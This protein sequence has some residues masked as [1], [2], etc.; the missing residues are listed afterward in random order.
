[1]REEGAALASSNLALRVLEGSSA[2]RELDLVSE[3]FHRIGRI[4]PEDQKVLTIPPEMPVRTALALM[5]K[6]RYSQ[7]PVVSGNTVTGVFSYRSFA[8][9]AA[10]ASLESWTHQKCAP[11]DLRV[12]DCTEDFSFARFKEEMVN[13]F[14]PLDR[15]NGILVGS[16]EKLI[17]ILTPM[18]LLRYLY[19][20]AGPFVLVSEIELV[21]R[22]LIRRVLDPPA[23]VAAAR[24]CLAAAY[25]SEQNVPTVL[26]EMT[27]DNYQQLITNGQTWAQFEPVLGP[28]RTRAGSKLKQV[29]DIRN[30]L[31]HFRRKITADDH[32]TLANHRKWLR[33]KVEQF[34]AVRLKGERS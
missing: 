28:T 20:V 19:Q 30:D 33:T 5:K 15:D 16:E 24:R 31:F 12:D 27:F 17:G 8:L 25:G 1:M 29:G 26:E 6:H 10:S 9:E 14:D 3:I 21:L 13:V 7:I 18:D 34:D 11:G 32:E 2:A 4:I 22:G 23:I